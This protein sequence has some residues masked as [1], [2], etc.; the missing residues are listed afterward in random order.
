MSW[1]MN[2][3]INLMS[4]KSEVGLML[5]M[6]QTRPSANQTSHVFALETSKKEASI[7]LSTGL[8]ISWGLAYTGIDLMPQARGGSQAGNH[9]DAAGV[10]NTPFS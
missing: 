8:L 4:P 6:S 5:M 7:D 3:A 1:G 10:T 9:M 2:T